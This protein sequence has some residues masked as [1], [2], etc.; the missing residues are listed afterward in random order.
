MKKVLLTLV[1]A[2]TGIFAANAQV[3][4]GGSLAF[5]TNKYED[6]RGTYYFL[7]PEVGYSFGNW[8]VATALGYSSGITSHIGGPTNKYI[9]NAFYV[10]PYV[11]YNVYNIEKFTLF[12]D[13][14]FDFIG[15]RDKY[16]VDGEITYGRDLQKTWQAGIKPGIAF[17]PQRNG[18]PC[19]ISGSSAT[20][21]V[22][23][24]VLTIFPSPM[25]QALVLISQHLQPHSACTIISDRLS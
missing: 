6:T 11:R 21:K 9:V 22:A 12:L 15:W 20:A 3:W 14:A 18:Q 5:N 24:A 16:N 2:F 25:T 7:G 13:G 1:L 23:W 10:M 4:L 17:H 8:S 19:S